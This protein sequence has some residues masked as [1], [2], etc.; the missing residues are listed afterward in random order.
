MSLEDKNSINPDDWSA[1]EM[2]KHTYREVLAI[3][4]QIIEGRNKTKTE[5]KALGDRINKVEDF[6]KAFKV[7][8]SF[9]GL[10]AIIL[11]A[12]KIIYDIYT[13]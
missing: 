1:L 10:L 3:K 11:G 7:I 9:I 6:V 5:I 8:T 2:L 4:S 12:I 13:L